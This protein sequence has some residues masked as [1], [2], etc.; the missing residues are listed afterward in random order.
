MTRLADSARAVRYYEKD[1]E[2]FAARYDSVS[3]EA[4]HGRIADHLPVTGASVLDVGA[5]SGRDARALAARGYKVVAVEPADSFRELANDGNPNITWV[6]DR[7]P[8]LA[9]LRDGK[10]RFEFILC[11][12]VLM[13]VP[14][15]HLAASFG[16]MA[17]L[18]ADSGK[19]AVSLRDPVQ[20]EPQALFHLHN[21]AA[22]VSA[23]A[24]VG[25]AMVAQADL[26]DALGRVPHHWR[27]F[28]FAKR[29]R[30]IRSV[31]RRA[32]ARALTSS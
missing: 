16:T 31:A 15:K 14:A 32:R 1:A 4:V 25:L 2:D 27:S 5:G 6:D 11:S 7:L 10:E 8:D 20:D 13:L 26:P 30:S 18:L 21:R 17:G 29:L 3:F 19:L 23:A 28:V 24:A 12:A 9:S 22:V